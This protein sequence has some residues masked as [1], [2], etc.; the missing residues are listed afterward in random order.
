MQVRDVQVQLATAVCAARFMTPGVLRLFTEDEP[1]EV[2]LPECSAL[3][4]PCLS[5]ALAQCATPRCD[6]P[7]MGTACRPIDLCVG[8]G[9]SSSC[10]NSSVKQLPD[11]FAAAVCESAP[12]SLYARR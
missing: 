7:C 12:G 11:G 2:V 10:Y 9:F 1:D 8:E 6:M 3:E 5:E 4:P